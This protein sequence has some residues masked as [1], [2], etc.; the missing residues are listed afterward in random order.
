MCHVCFCKI[1]EGY[2]QT[3]CTAAATMTHKVDFTSGNFQ[4]CSSGSTDKFADHFSLLP[5]S[6]APNNYKFLKA[7]CNNIV[8]PDCGLIRAQ[9]YCSILG[10]ILHSQN[11]CTVFNNLV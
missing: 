4:F 10:T 6:L 2:G 5:E 8:T 11:F 1:V 9:Q 7:R 3:E